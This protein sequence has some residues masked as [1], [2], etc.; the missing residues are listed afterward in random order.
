M[1][2]RSYIAVLIA[3]TIVAAVVRLNNVL[4]FPGLFGYDGF[5]HFSYIWFLADAGRV[6]LANAGWEFFQ[7]PLYYFLMS[8]IWKL[9][10]GFDPIMRL[11]IGSGIVALLGLVPAFATGVIV[12]DF[13]PGKRLIH[14]LAV[15]LMLFLPMHLYSSMFIGNEA[16]TAVLSNAGL[17]A[18]WFLLKRDS[19][20]RAVVLGLCLGLAMLTKFTAVVVVAA[21]FGIL[22]FRMLIDRDYR[23]G[24]RTILLV[25]IVMLSVCGWFYLRNVSVY[26]TPFQMS[27]TE[28]FLLNA[29]DSQ[30]HGER[31]ILEYILFD[32]MVM[33]DP[34]W[35][36]G[37]SLNGPR[38]ADVEYNPLRESVL[39]GLYANTWFDGFG[40]FSLP[41]ITESEVARRGGQIL[42]TL[43]IVPTGLILFGLWTAC[44]R[45]RREGWDDTVVFMLI[46]FAAMWTVF[47]F[48]TSS[49]PTHAAIKATYFMPISVV[50]SFWFAIGLDRI[51]SLN[52]IYR[53]GVTAICTLLAVVACALFTHGLVVGERW[54]AD[55]AAGATWQNLYGVVYYA[56]GERAEARTFF[57]SAASQGSHLAQENLATLAFEDGNLTEALYRSRR[58]LRMEIQREKI[59]N[60]SS[61]RHFRLGR[62]E[63][64][65]SV[66]VIYDRLGWTL[67]AIALERRVLRL[68]VGIPEASYNLGILRL[69]QALEVSDARGAS[70]RT[71]VTLADRL[72]GESLRIDPAFHEARAMTAVVQALQGNCEAADRLHGE[73][74]VLKANSYRRYPMETGPGDV[75]AAGLHRRRQI[76]DVPRPLQASVALAECRG[77][78]I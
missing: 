40:G 64:L 17:L 2:R 42:L 37:L 49:V 59:G 12:R 27:R 46:A 8:V 78:A 60:A 51:D 14:I 26:G 74:E 45:L 25:A 7:P 61:K 52:R 13:L 15:G 32:P 18:L 36:R 22:G 56:G 5:A 73:S 63:Q 23:R 6:P 29:E 20:Q 38:P 67:E 57:E 35:P 31:G 11:Q 34:V 19:W 47:I 43:S 33:I 4:T 72:F 58:A 28:V 76:T 53:R 9:F 39:T 70:R 24:I 75:H 62:A 77:R 16:L 65:N 48:G 21:A 69:R 50:F 10:A 44:I 55:I 66:A 30:P 68:N 41:P 71:L 54:F 1:S 3:M